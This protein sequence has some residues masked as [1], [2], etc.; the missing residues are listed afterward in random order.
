MRKLL[1]IPPDLC[2]LV[3]ATLFSS[4]LVYAVKNNRTQKKNTK[5]PHPKMVAICQ[6]CEVLHKCVLWGRKRR[7]GLFSFVGFC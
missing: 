6:A 1:N 2:L 5:N 3:D 4:S 7:L